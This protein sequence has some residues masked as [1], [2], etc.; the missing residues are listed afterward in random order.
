[1]RVSVENQFGKKSQ[2]RLETELRDGKV[3]LSDVFFTAPFKVMLPFYV[4]PDYIQV[5]V[6]SASAGIMEGD[7]QEFEIHIKEKTSMEY[8]SQAYEKIHKMKEGMARRHTKIVVD[9]EAYL[10]YTPLPTIPFQDSAFENSLD[11]EL[12]EKTSRLLFQEILTCGRAARGEV[13]AYRFFHNRISV[14][15]EGKLIYFDNTRYEPQL[16]QMDGMGMYEGYTHLLNLVFF[17]IEKTQSWIG[18]V[19]SLLEQNEDMEGGVTRISCGDVAVRILGRSAEA[20]LKI[21][22]QI[23]RIDSEQDS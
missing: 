18:K 14:C 5:M 6:L 8:L 20:L 13:F 2:V 15:R 10:K 11:I 17:N 23:Q 7:D 16:F 3:I 21:S 19:R 1:M 4:R 12:R 22:E 9:R